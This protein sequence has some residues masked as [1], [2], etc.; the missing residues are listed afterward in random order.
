MSV[1]WQ[2]RASATPGEVGLIAM[3]PESF[4]DGVANGWTGADPHTDNVGVSIIP[5]S[6]P[7]PPVVNVKVEKTVNT[8]RGTQLGLGRST[9]A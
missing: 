6:G 3:T 9:R 2:G 4:S 5:D 1:I 8:V 7:P